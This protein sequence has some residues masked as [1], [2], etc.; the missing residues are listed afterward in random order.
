MLHVD[1]AGD[2]RASAPKA[3]SGT[4]EALRAA[5]ARLQSVDR[6]RLTA[7]A[8]LAVT[9][10]A[11]LSPAIPH[12]PAPNAGWWLGGLATTGLA[13]V[14]ATLVRR[15]FRA[16]WAQYLPLL[17]FAIAVQMLRAADGGGSSGFSP[18]LILPVVWYALHGTKKAV[19]AAVA[20][21]G[22]VQFGPLLFVG[23]P[24]YPVTLWRAA[25][26]WVVISGLI[27][28][29][30]HRL[31]AAIRAKSAAAA[32]SEAQSRAA[33]SDAP[34]PIAVIGAS[35]AQHGVIL[36]ANAALAA[37]LGRRADEIVNHSVLEFTHPDDEELTRQHLLEPAERQICRTIEKRYVHSSGRAIPVLITYSRLQ[38]PLGGMPSIVAHIQ[39]VTDH[40]EAQLEMLAALEQ[41]KQTSARLRR[42][43]QASST[44]TS[45]VS[46]EVRQPLATVTRS[47]EL[48]LSSD[49]HRLDR[50][51]RALLADVEREAQRLSAIFAKLVTRQEPAQE[52]D[53]PTLDPV[54]L[55]AVVCGAIESARPM[56]RGRD[57]A[58]QS[59]VSLAGAQVQGD[60]A[61][62]DRA[63][64]SLLDN[65]MK[66]TPPGGA[67]DAQAR[68][69]SNAVVID[70][71]DT[72][73][74]VS[75]EDQDRIFDRFYRAQEA[76]RRSIPGAGLGLTIAKAI[77]EQ[78]HGSIQV[79]SELGAGSTF[80]LMLPLRAEPART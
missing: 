54:N 49:T 31:V 27:G 45:T 68:V 26:L 43:E 51:Q 73:I 33:F 41:E 2:P 21:V 12:T 5:F 57:L 22:A 17:L 74:G 35:G 62:L 34:T 30:A 64:M 11:E 6:A 72:G 59:D 28:L 7:Y 8:F 3:S 77:V 36:N 58:L 52:D 71:T 56:A 55:E 66:F 69:R 4:A 79:Y 48:L 61:K 44:L 19:L 29:V 76:E 70:V 15:H 25:V 37:L 32:M 18:L 40:R 16:Q 42:L 9:V 80:T 23:P 20:V 60:A 50:Q 78:H 13:A 1:V 75:P 65:A 67:I 53:E 10:F 63:L 24:Q 46:D 38:S 14:L 47:V 39:D